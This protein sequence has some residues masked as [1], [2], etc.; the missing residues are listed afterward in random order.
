MLAIITTAEYSAT[1]PIEL[2]IPDDSQ[3]KDVSLRI[4]RTATLDGYCTIDNMGLSHSDRALQLQTGHCSKETSA[5]LWSLVQQ[6]TAAWLAVGA[7]F[8]TGYL[9]RYREA[10]STVT[11]TFLVERK[12]SV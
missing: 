7:E 11:L 8:F 2:E 4:S 9:N 6:G 10:G 1:A 5:A 12:L 3:I